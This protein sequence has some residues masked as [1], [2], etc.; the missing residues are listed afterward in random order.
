M[1]G[2]GRGKEKP[3]PPPTDLVS[4]MLVVCVTPLLTTFARISTWFGFDR[5]GGQRI[6]Q[7]RS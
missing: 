2:Y 3:L 4:I 5:P 6:P 7:N 1:G